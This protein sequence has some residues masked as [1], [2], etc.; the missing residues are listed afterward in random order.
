MLYQIKDCY[1]F[2]RETSLLQAFRESDNVL[3]QGVQVAEIIA[4]PLINV[5]FADVRTVM[6]NKVQP[7]G[8][9]IA[10]GD[11]APVRA[12]LFTQHY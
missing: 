2:H 9:G 3:R 7:Y 1:L 5:D 12:K 6:E 8:I 4:V 10:S 11:R